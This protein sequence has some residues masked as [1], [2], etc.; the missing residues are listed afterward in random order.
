MSDHGHKIGSQLL[1]QFQLLDGL[2]EFHLQIIQPELRPNPSQKNF[3]LHGL[4]H[5]IVPAAVQPSHHVT[6]GIP[7][8]DHNNR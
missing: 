1:Q 2:L 8:G 4:G 6:G 3:Q 5:I 7:T